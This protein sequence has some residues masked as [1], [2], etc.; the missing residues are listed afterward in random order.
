[1]YNHRVIFAYLQL[2]RVA[3]LLNMIPS[4]WRIRRSRES[5]QPKLK[6]IFYPSSSQLSNLPNFSCI[7]S[8]FTI[9][10]A[11]NF[12]A[13]NLSTHLLLTLI[14]CSGIKSALQTRLLS[15]HKNTLKINSKHLLRKIIILKGDVAAY[16]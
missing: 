16:F 12:K 15:M 13:R 5:S 2:L 14:R 6:I 8:Q 3:G 1:M 11:N 9:Y 7:F 10:K 4:I